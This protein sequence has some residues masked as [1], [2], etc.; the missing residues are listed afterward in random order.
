MQPDPVAGHDARASPSGTRAW[1]RS[2]SSADTLTPV[3]AALRLR[4]RLAFILE[5]VEGGA[6]YGRYS[7]VGV[8]GRTLERGPGRRGGVGRRLHGAGAVRGGGPARGAARGPAGRPV[9]RTAHFPVP[10]RPAWATWPMTRPRAGSGCPFRRRT[11][12]ACRRPCSTCPRWSSPSTT[13]PRPRRSRPSA[14]DGADE[15]LAGTRAARPAGPGRAT[16][17]PARG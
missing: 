9:G 3:A 5:S 2:R 1:P 17:P 11:R 14:D 8:R 4:D 7:F 10:S 6:R 13:S 16:R 15:R 12:S